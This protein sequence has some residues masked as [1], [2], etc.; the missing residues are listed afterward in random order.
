MLM[1]FMEIFLYGDFFMEIFFFFIY[2]YIFFMEIFFFFYIYMERSMGPNIDPC[3]TPR[4][5]I[6]G[7]E[8]DSNI[9][10]C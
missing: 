10:H 1:L 8:S 9:E 5:N 6:R 7:L 3:G 4:S 2:I